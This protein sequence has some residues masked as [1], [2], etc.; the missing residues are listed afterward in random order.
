[1]K[2]IFHATHGMDIDIQLLADACNI[3]PQFGPEFALNVFV[4]FL[5][6]EYHMHHVLRVGMRHVPHLQC[7]SF[8]I[9]RTERLRAGLTCTAPPAFERGPSR[10]L[11]AR[12]TPS[13]HCSE[14][15]MKDCNGGPLALDTNL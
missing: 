14:F 7:S 4:P 13:R 12:T 6:A 3:C 2:V 11:E 9:P 1:M 8:Y 10:N 5:R 15:V